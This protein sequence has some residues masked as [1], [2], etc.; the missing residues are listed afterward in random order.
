MKIGIDIRNIGKKRTGDEVVFFNLVKNFA[1][2]DQLNEY[3]LFTDILDEE[4][5]RTIKTSL[6]IKKNPRFKLVPLKTSDRFSWN[7]WTIGAYLRQN[8]VDIYLTQYV[9][10]LFVPKKIA[11]II[12]DV[13]FNAYGK[14]I[15]FSDLLFLNILIPLA[16]K[17]ADKVIG[18][19]KFTRDEILKYY[20]INP[21]KVTWIHN[22]AGDNFREEISPEQLA[23]VRTKFK[24]PE[25]FILYIGT[26]QPRKNLPNLI[27]AYAK[28]PTATKAEVKLVLAGGKGHNFDRGIDAAIKKHSL[29]KN[30]LFTGYVG[31]KYKPALFK[32]SAIFCNPSLYEGFGIT[33]LEA[34]TLGIP[35]V[36]SDIP[37][38][39]E[40]AQNSIVYSN[41]AV[42]RD[43]TEKLN[44]VLINEYLRQELA[45]K[46][47][48]QA[49][50]FS[51]VKT[52]ERMLKIFS[53]TA[54]HNNS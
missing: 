36:A 3:V 39:R 22:A 28:L 17:R 37:P 53:D 41:P 32:A 13:S 4:S 5:L 26:M 1:K 35:V 54:D 23:S 43:L 31:E 49:Q 48:A 8:P 34:M 46:E 25:K 12:H 40:V 14:F 10:P 7:F 27:E 50:N 38:H 15:Q 21:E 11:T 51:W 30:V 47:H 29:R 33:I 20:K 6:G 24:L 16:M 9:T 2:I 18:V 45:D 44:S 42:A 52:A 19:S